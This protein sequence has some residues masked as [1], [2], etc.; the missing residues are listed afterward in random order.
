MFERNIHANGSN[1]GARIIEQLFPTN[2]DGYTLLYLVVL[3]NVRFNINVFLYLRQ[4]IVAVNGILHRGLRKTYF[5]FPNS[6]E[7]PYQSILSQ[8]YLFF[9]FIVIICRIYSHPLF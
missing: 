1:I 9:A 5:V 4:I 7:N 2:W 6:R 3:F 8:Q